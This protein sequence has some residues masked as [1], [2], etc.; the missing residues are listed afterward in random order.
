MVLKSAAKIQLQEFIDSY[1]ESL[2]IEGAQAL[3]KNVTK[4][5]NL[6]YRYEFNKEEALRICDEL[7]LQSGFIAI[8]G[9][10]LSSRITIR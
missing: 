6:S 5:L 7:K 2:G 9:G 10:I 4:K 8:V 3:L 1:K